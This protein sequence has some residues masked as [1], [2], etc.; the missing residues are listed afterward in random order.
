MPVTNCHGVLRR[1]PQPALAAGAL[2]LPN[3]MTHKIS[4]LEGEAKDPAE[5]LPTTK[6]KQC[7]R[8]AGGWTRYQNTTMNHS[9]NTQQHT[10]VDRGGSRRR[11][12]RI[13]RTR[14]ARTRVTQRSQ[15]PH[16]PSSPFHRRRRQR[17]LGNLLSYLNE[18]T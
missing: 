3:R 13:K 17:G 7:K 9:G 15:T 4:L 8:S 11:K 10:H 18:M 14:D 2:F 5:L 6:R 12:G 16:S 1:E